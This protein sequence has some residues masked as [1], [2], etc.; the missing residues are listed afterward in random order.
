MNL[1]N[2]KLILNDKFIKKYKDEFISNSILDKII[3]Y[4]IRE[5]RYKELI[6]FNILIMRLREIRD[7]ILRR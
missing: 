7:K 5:N 6:F 3:N 4:F 2:I 1:H